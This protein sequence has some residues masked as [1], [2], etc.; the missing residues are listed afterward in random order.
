[1]RKDLVQDTS[2]QMQKEE[3]W[4]KQRKELVI[5]VKVSIERQVVNL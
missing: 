1:M 3:K 2:T 4:K 5:T